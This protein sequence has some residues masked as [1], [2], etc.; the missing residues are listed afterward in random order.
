MPNAV[1]YVKT[2]LTK[3][4]ILNLLNKYNAQGIVDNGD[5]IRCCCPIHRGN[6]PTGFVW[7]TE[8]GLW[9]CFTGDCGGGSVFDFIANV[10]HMNVETQ[11]TDI[12][13]TTA[14]IIGMD[15]SNLEICAITNQ[16][17]REM[18]Q[19]LSYISNRNR[20]GNLPYD[21]QKLGTLYKIKSYRDFTEDTVSHFDGK[22]SDI[23]KRIVV[24]LKNKDGIIIGVSMRRTLHDDSPK[25]LHRPKHINTGYC[26]YNLHEIAGDTIII[27]EGV[28]DVWKLWQIGIKNAGATYGAHLTEEQHNLILERFPNVI[29]SYDSDDAGKKATKK[30]IDMLKHKC[31]LKVLSLDVHDPGE[32]RDIEH[33]NSL[34]LLNWW[35][36]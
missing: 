11:F 32:I 27:C 33:Y 12:V 35:E 7:N 6:N 10:E 16:W 25:W 19:W 18:R 5:N 24:P 17:E 28:F 15:I 1:E 13:K 36:I 14:Q 4:I 34:K 31:N 21:L 20:Q 8:N 2:H 22:Y 23:Y 9:F 29:L 3:D 26:I 30:A